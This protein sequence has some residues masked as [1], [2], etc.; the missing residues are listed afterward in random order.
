MVALE[1]LDV[2]IAEVL[3]LG[4]VLGGLGERVVLSGL[5]VVRQVVVGDGDVG[6]VA[7]GLCSLM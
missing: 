1:T 6:V 4:V 7:L 5:Q 3:P 2:R